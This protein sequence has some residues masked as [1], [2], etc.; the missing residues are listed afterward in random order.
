MG[1]RYQGGILGGSSIQHTTT[2]S[3]RLG[4]TANGFTTSNRMVVGILL[5]AYNTCKRK[6][7]CG[8]VPYRNC[9]VDHRAINLSPPGG[10]AEIKIFFSEPKKRNNE[11]KPKTWYSFVKCSGMHRGP[12]T[13][14][15]WF[16]AHYGHHMASRCILHHHMVTHQRNTYPSNSGYNGGMDHSSMVIRHVFLSMCRVGAFLWLATKA[17]TATEKRPH[18]LESGALVSP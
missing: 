9:T 10:V 7:R 16:N 4:G 18:A 15:C 1:S 12:S 17:L 14:G 11:L 3:V 5:R 6:G 8:G 2:H 13:C